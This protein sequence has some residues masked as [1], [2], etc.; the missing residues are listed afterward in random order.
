[1]NVMYLLYLVMKN[2]KIVFW[3]SL[4][5][6]L[7]AAFWMYSKKPKEA[8]T[9]SKDLRVFVETAVVKKGPISKQL[10]L[11][12]SLSATQ[13]AVLVAEV[14]GRIKEILFPQGKA[15]KKGEILVQLDD[16]SYESMV[17]KAKAKVDLMRSEYKRV[18]ELFENGYGAKHALDKALF[19]FKAAEAE[20]K[21]AT[22]EYK[23]TKI[24]APFDGFVGLHKSSQGMSVGSFVSN[25][26][27]LVHISSLDP[28]Y[29]D[30]P[31][32]ESV[33]SSIFVGKMLEVVVQGDN[34]PQSA[35]VIAIEPLADSHTHSVRVRASLP[36]GDGFFKP[37][38]FAHVLLKT[39]EKEEAVL[40]PASALEREND[41]SFVYVVH[42]GRAIRRP[43]EVG[44]S[45][46][47]MT[48]ILQ[49]VEEGWS[50]VTVGQMKLQDG[51]PVR[52][53]ES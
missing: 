22:I 10:H 14:P 13:S 23:K 28:L 24:R 21:T 26:E 50:I 18:K 34:L 7:C 37:G 47:N 17:E 11:N 49:G 38:Q 15:V 6:I 42:Q 35:T 2:K 39:H 4:T 43:V 52:T 45:N 3:S 27:E 41:Q 48:E 46:E 40:I 20:L 53:A 25:R 5:F 8:K 51:M 19:E 12:G 9:L 33:L 30:F 36:N 29:V 1:M 32:P 16:D 44:I 31:V